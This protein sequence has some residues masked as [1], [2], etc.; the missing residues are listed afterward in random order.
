MHRVDG[1]AQI[2]VDEKLG[3]TFPR[4]L[5][6]LL[7]F[8]LLDGSLA[9]RYGERYLPVTE[10]EVAEKPKAARPEKSAKARRVNG[11]GSNWNQNFDL[12]KGPKV[13]QAA[14][15]SGHRQDEVTG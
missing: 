15:E 14:Q 3:L 6:S 10:C 2:Q 7:R 5:R 1:A 4:V 9:V 8:L 11:R 12:K 13:W